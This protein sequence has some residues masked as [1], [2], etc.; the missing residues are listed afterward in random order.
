LTVPPYP[1]RKADKRDKGLPIL[2]VPEDFEHFYL[3]DV[4]FNNNLLQWSASDGVL[5]KVGASGKTIKEAIS[6]VYERAGSIRA[7]GLQYRTDIA[8][9]AERSIAQLKKWGYLPQE[10]LLRRA[11][12]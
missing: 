5:M 7:E 10:N 2:G 12:G 3:T 8:A 11:V 6:K 4:F 1:H 9:D